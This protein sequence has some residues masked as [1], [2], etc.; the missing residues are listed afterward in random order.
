MAVL[1]YTAHTMHRITSMYHEAVAYFKG[2]NLLSRQDRS[3]PTSFSEP[4]PDL[5]G[6]QFNLPPSLPEA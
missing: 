6:I 3:I 4:I 2:Q 1:S 5:S